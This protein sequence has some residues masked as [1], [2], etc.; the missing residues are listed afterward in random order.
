M[1]FSFLTCEMKYD[2]MI[3]DVANRQNA[4]SMILAMKEIVE[5]YKAVKREKE[6][7]R[8]ILAFS[9]S[10]DHRSMKIYDHYALIDENKIIFYR[11]FIH[12]F[13]FT[14]LNDKEK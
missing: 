11:H 10:H 7:H 9:I 3:L 4:Y 13:D 14:T 12:T 5:L 8:E 2:V 1:Y 6:L